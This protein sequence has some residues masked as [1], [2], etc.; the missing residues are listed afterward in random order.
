MPIGRLIIHNAKR[1]P[2][3]RKAAR[4]KVFA[5]N[6]CVMRVKLMVFRILV[7]AVL[8]FSVEAGASGVVCGSRSHDQT[9]VRSAHDSYLHRKYAVLDCFA[10][11]PDRFVNS[12]S[13]IIG[14]GAHDERFGLSVC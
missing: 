6:K 3:G 11:K 12:D 10:T 5:A 14:V 2:R 4:A 13:V 8:F 1:L 9:H 7:L